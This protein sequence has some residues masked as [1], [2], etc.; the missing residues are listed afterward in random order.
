MERTRSFAYYLK[1]AVNAE[2]SDIK[3]RKVPIKRRRD[4]E[5]ER[6]RKPMDKKVCE[7]AKQGTFLQPRTLVLTI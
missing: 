4:S 2:T 3:T 1:S 6:N 7:F 5:S